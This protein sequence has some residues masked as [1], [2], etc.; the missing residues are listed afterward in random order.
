MRGVGTQPEGFFDGCVKIREGFEGLGGCVV[1][2]DGGGDGVQLL[3]D[4]SLAVRGLGDL[5]ENRAESD[6]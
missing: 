3:L 4:A 2:G 1:V 6:T 5:V